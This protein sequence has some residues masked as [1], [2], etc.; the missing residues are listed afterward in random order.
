MNTLNKYFRYRQSLIDQYI[1]G[2]LTKSEYLEENLNA[3]LSLNIKPF[4]NIDT[5]EK[6]LFNYQYY[7]AL[8]KEAKMTSKLYLNKEIE[9]SYNEK[10]DYYYSRKDKATLKVLEIIDFK[11]VEAYFIKVNSKYL[12]GKL[13]EIILNDYNMILHS[14]NESLLKRLKDENVFNNSVKM[15]LIDEYINQKY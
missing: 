13:F 7:N 14:A 12:K 1:K 5:P 6:G 2:D 10:S 15:S 9:N 11:N 3:V 4:K 8:A